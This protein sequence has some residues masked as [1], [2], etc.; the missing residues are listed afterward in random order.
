MEMKELGFFLLGAAVGAVAA[1]MFDPSSGQELRSQIQTSAEKDLE[2]L[3]AEW[4]KGM[5]KANEQLAQMQAELK[6]AL[7]REEAESPVQE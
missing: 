1:L 4:E 2:R 7:Q 6:Q 3:Q 5:Q